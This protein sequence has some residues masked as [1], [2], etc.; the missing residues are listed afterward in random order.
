MEASGTLTVG[1]TVIDTHFRGGQEPQCD[2]AFDADAARSETLSPQLREQTRLI[3]AF[4]EASEP[5][6]HGR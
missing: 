3:N 4:L 5:S 6:Q 1:R 2:V